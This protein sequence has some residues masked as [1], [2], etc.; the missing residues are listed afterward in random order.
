MT[1]KLPN[2]L[3]IRTDAPL[4]QREP[5]GSFAEN[6]AFYQ[7][8]ASTVSLLKPFLPLEGDNRV[9][10]D[11]EELRRLREKDARMTWRPMSE[12]RPAAGFAENHCEDIDMMLTYGEECGIVHQSLMNR[13]D[14]PVTLWMPLPLPP[15]K[16]DQEAADEKSFQSWWSA[17]HQTEE[18]RRA[19]WEQWKGGAK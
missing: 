6:A 15:S 14:D 8:I 17:I 16:E 12:E 19:A 11:P 7:G 4:Y 10:I 3:G 5:C 18:T 9:L 1:E 13:T 2:P